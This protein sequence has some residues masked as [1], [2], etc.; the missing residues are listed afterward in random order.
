MLAPLVPCIFFHQK[1]GGL[2]EKKTHVDRVRTCFL[3]GI[4]KIW[5]FPKIGVPQNGWFI[6]ENPI[7]MDDLGIP[8]FLETPIFNVSAPKREVEI[9]SHW[10]HKVTSN[11]I[12]FTAWIVMLHFKLDTLQGTNIS[13]LK[14]AGKTI[15]LFYRW[16]LLV[17]RRVGTSNISMKGFRLRMFCSCLKISCKTRP[18]EIVAWESLPTCLP[19]AQLGGP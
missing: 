12:D 5:V 10:A 1:L 11:S 17:P 9:S 7:K 13:H 2:E 14:V 16:D 18:P 15:F 4:C 19:V 6:M 3:S 8:L